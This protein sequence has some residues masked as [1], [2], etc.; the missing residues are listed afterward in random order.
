V[1]AQLTVRTGTVVS[2]QVSAQGRSVRGDD[3]DAVGLQF[4]SDPNA[5]ITND[6]QSG[7]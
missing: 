1:L 5:R 6:W 4:S 7:H 2:G 3:W